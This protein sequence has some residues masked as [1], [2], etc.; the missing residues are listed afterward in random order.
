M[1]SIE[2]TQNTILSVD[3]DEIMEQKD[4]TDSQKLGIDITHEQTE[5]LAKIL[6]QIQTP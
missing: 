5:E 1:T 4:T 2:N 3:V 6:E